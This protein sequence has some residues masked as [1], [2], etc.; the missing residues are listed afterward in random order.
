[1]N[2]VGIVFTLEG[3]LKGPTLLVDLSLASVQV[4]VGNPQ[5]HILF[6][7]ILYSGA[8]ADLPAQGQVWD[9]GVRFGGR[10]VD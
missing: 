6:P 1:M 7:V 8:D 3:P 10:G 5:S 4:L 2:C 9:S